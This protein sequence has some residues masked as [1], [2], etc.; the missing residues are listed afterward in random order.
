MSANKKWNRLGSTTADN[1]FHH[2]SRLAM[3]RYIPDE[4]DVVSELNTIKI[5]Y[6]RSLNLGPEKP[7]MFSLYPIV[8]LL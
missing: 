8:L 1:E 5:V 3:S 7:A 2:S 6:K 4:T